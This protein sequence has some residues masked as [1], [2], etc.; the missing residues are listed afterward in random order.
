MHGR[1]APL[2]ALASLAFTLSGCG[3]TTTSSPAPSTGSSGA[4][5]IPP[6]HSAPAQ[7]VPPGRA[8]PAQFIAGADS[9]CADLQGKDRPL[10]RRAEALSR[11]TTSMSRGLLA[12][13]FDESIAFARAADAKLAAL[14]RPVAERASIA[15][16]LTGYDS[17]A[18][19]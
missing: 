8:T 10:E 2:A 6:G 7:P 11:E 3:S 19:T 4:K 17:E 18:R 9:I 15:Q 1:Y 5:P 14:A 16:L 12:N 13:L